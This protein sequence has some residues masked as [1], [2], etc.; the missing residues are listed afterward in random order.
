MKN[1]KIRLWGIVI[2][3]ISK[4]KKSNQKSKKMASKFQ[5]TAHPNYYERPKIIIP[6]FQKA[7]NFKRPQGS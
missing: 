7:E 2:I 3:I 5:K 1:L 6:N 4:I